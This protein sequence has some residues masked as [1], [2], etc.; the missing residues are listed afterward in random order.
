MLKHAGIEFTC[1][2]P[3]EIPA[4]ASFAPPAVTFPAGNTIGQSVAIAVKVGKACGLAPES[5]ADDGKALQI[6]GDITDVAT[7]MGADKPAE[8]IATWMERFENI[9]GDADYLV[10][11]KLSYADFFLYPV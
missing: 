10:G 11:N 8:R 6:L 4:G 2:G 7:E 9:I 5:E 3:E 1:K